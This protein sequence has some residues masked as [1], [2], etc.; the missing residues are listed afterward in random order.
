MAAA[1][2]L[3][4]AQAGDRK[5]ALDRLAEG[6]SLHKVGFVSPAKSSGD[7]HAVRNSMKVQERGDLP[8][9]PVTPFE[10]RVPHAGDKVSGTDQQ[11]EKGPTT[12][13]RERRGITFFRFDSKVGAISVQPVVG[14]VNGAQ[15]SLGF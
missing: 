12:T 11:R 15:L 13:P 7:D 1:V 6:V 9:F 5:S 3:Q 10:A 4:P 8:F 14:G 2:G